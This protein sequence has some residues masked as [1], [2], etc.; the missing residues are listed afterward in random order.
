[1]HL[2][3]VEMYVSS[4]REREREREREIYS[5][6]HNGIAK[7]STPAKSSTTARPKRLRSKEMFTS[8]QRSKCHC[9]HLRRNQQ[10]F[11]RYDSELLERQKIAGCK[12]N[13][14]K[15]DHSTHSTEGFPVSLQI[16]RANLKALIIQPTGG[17]KYHRCKI[18][19]RTSKAC[20]VLPVLLFVSIVL[21]RAF[22]RNVVRR[23]W[24]SD[25][26]INCQAFPVGPQRNR[27]IPRST[28]RSHPEYLLLHHRR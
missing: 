11:R 23:K 17:L 13:G 12:I 2:D 15:H 24:A 22:H 10:E 4:C 21:A 20:V 14:P 3:Y 9:P 25:R 28:T 7:A 16:E 19:V 27:N 5:K 1:M 26:N 6:V 18:V 8:C